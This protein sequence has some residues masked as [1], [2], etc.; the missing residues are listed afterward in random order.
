MK[1]WEMR[2]EASI[3]GRVVKFSLPRPG[4]QRGEFNFP[5]QA[6]VY[7]FNNSWYVRSPLTGFGSPAHLRHWNNAILFC[8]EGAPGY[9]PILCDPG[10]APTPEDCGAF[11]KADHG[12]AR[13]FGERGRMPFFD[14]FRWLPF[15]E[16]GRDLEG[17]AG[18]FDWDV[19]SN[20]FPA[21]LRR[22]HGMESNGRLADPG[23]A[24]PQI[25][26]FSLVQGAA[27]ARSAC[28]V[29]EIGEGVLGCRKV[30]PSRSFAGAVAPDGSLYAG[31]WSSGQELP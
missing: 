18:K 10:P 22:A 3:N 29:V 2:C 5:S 7:M 1:P 27:A 9:D 14:C 13:H 24:A 23:F 30:D 20:G 15:D 31:P 17:L 11:A 12:L 25:G 4:T 16:T 28:L 21:A 6:P 8:E 19:S 26:D